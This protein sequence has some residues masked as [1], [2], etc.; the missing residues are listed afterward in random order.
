[1]SKYFNSK[2]VVD[3]LINGDKEKNRFVLLFDNSKQVR[4]FSDR[5]GNDL[6]NDMQVKLSGDYKYRVQKN[7]LQVNDN[8]IYIGLK[9]DED[10]LLNSYSEDVIR[11]FRDDEG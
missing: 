8:K 9:H 10:L 6:K 5:I 11:Y 7:L 1:M 2:N 4:E 3:F